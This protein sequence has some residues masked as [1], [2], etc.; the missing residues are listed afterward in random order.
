MMMIAFK[1]ALGSVKLSILWKILRQ[2][3]QTAEEK[4][5]LELIIQLHTKH[6]VLVD[7]Q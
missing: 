1:N 5:I 2:K 7:I 3:A 4:H 6:T